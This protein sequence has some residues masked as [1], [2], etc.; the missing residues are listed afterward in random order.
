MAGVKGAGGKS[1]QDR[2]LAAKVR[3]KALKDIYAVLTEQ[4]SVKKWG[5]FKQDIVLKLAGTVLP[6]LNEH[7][8]P[9]GKELPV[10]IF[11]VQSYNGNG[12]S[13]PTE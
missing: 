11:N 13:K 5:K 4:K 10:P 2:E 9:E 3:N 12:E 7:T 1:F 6:R 8:G